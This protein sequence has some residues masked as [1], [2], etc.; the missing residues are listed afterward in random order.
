MSLAGTLVLTLVIVAMALSSLASFVPYIPG[1]V[2]VWGIGAAYAAFT[3]LERVTFLALIAMTGLM[4]IGS[5]ADFWMQL[6][7][8]RMKGGSCL[9]T[10]GSLI[11]GALATFLIPILGTLIGMIGGALAIEFLHKGELDPALDAGKNALQVYLLSAITE[12][13]SSLLILA[14]FLLSIWYTA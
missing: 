7:G 3:G 12:F 6:A 10:L 13:G 14:I 8:M 5:T 9:A 11:G 2:L 4:M 1:P